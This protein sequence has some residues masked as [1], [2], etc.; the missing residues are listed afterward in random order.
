MLFT[1]YALTNRTTRTITTVN[2]VDMIEFSGLSTGGRN[3]SI[4]TKLEDA[5]RW[6]N[7]ELIQVAF[8]YLN[9]DDREILK[10]GIDAQEWETMFA[11]TQEEDE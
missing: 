9:A 3:F 7:G 2:D 5:Q 6:V 1:P 4:V 11:G 8:P 10:T